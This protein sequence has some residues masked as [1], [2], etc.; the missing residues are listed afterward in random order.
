MLTLEERL[1]GGLL[2]AV[3]GERWGEQ[4]WPRWVWQPQ[5]PGVWGQWLYQGCAYW[6]GRSSPVPRAGTVAEA[7]VLV[8]PGLVLDYPRMEQV[9][10]VVATAALP[11]VVG[12]WAMV[13]GLALQGQVGEPL[14]DAETW[15][16]LADSVVDFQQGADDPLTTLTGGVRRGR[17]PLTL[18]L[19]GFLLGAY[20]GVRS[21]PAAAVVSLLNDRAWR[22][23]GT[24]LC[25][26]WAG[27]AAGQAPWAV[28]AVGLG[29]R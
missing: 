14:A 4:P 27:V 8:L 1:Q 13:L 22:T 7:L 20:G 19:T 12:D 17:S 11:P 3:L 9:P 21:L 25:A 24:A 5:T 26:R 28:T 2:G 29:S 18:F 16:E 6:V 15:P 23:L 10:A